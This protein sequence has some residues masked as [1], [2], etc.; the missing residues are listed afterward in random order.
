MSIAGHGFGRPDADESLPAIVERA[1]QD[2]QW[3]I[4]LARLGYR[5]VKAAFIRQLR[6]SPKAEVFFGIKH[7]NHYPT[8]DFV[9]SWLR[10]E[11]KRAM[12]RLRWP[13]LGAM[14]AT[15]VAVI[16]FAVSCHCIA[17]P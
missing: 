8:M 16:T 6:E 17:L 9:R 12:R 3:E 4:A 2:R 10:T 15:I 1:Q 7:L 11:R 13:F 5:Q 14:L